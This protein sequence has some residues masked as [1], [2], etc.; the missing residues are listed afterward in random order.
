MEFDRIFKFH[1]A[2]KKKIDPQNSITETEVEARVQTLLKK[3]HIVPFR[4]KMLS[5]EKV[6]MMPLYP[7]DLERFPK[8]KFLPPQQINRLISELLNALNF[9]HGMGFCHMDIKSSNI[10]IDRD[11]NYCLID[12]G[13]ICPIGQK[14]QSTMTNLPLELQD[15][16][17][18]IISA[19]NIDFWMLAIT[20][21]DLCEKVDLFIV[22][23]RALSKENII[24]CLSESSR[25][26]CYGELLNILRA[27][28]I[29]VLNEEF[30][31]I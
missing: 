11:A 10:C 27:H 3:N 5:L 14:T 29:N 22:K 26:D 7:I 28:I 12:L 17:S 2:L 13:S 31:K 1:V 21:M 4:L 25:K 24:K 16:H 23:S 15:D 8:T 20:L 18:N 19:E 6:M 9:L 30:E